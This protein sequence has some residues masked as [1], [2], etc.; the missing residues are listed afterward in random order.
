MSGSTENRTS[1]APE[2]SGKRDVVLSWSTA[3][4]MLPLVRH[5]VEEVRG[6]RQ[7]VRDMEREK[8]V[9]DRRRRLLGWED[10]SRRYRLGEEIAAGERSLADC[11]AELA[12]LGVEMLH[13][14]AGLVG[15]PTRVNDRPALFSW[16]PGEETVQFWHFPE[17][18]VRRPVP[19]SWTQPFGQAARRKG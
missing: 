9:L 2:K 17:E 16:L 12:N 18:T 3:R 4:R 8:D 7:R 11:L 15:F 10:R 6:L 13:A 1:G 19:A 5:I 14:D